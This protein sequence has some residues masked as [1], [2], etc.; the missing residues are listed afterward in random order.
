MSDATEAMSVVDAIADG[1][2]DRFLV[3]IHLA[4]QYRLTATGR[5][6]RQELL[7]DFEESEKAR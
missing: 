1:R 3:S 7:A 2:L 4:V 5:S 6:V